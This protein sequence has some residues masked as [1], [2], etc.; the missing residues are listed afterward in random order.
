MPKRRTSQLRS[1]RQLKV[2]RV[3]PS[4]VAAASVGT[5]ETHVPTEPSSLPLA[6]KTDIGTVSPRHR[7]RRVKAKA[8]S[9]AIT[10]PAWE[11]PKESVQHQKALSIVAMRVA[12]LTTEEIA[13]ALNIKPASVNQ[14]MWLA[15][16]NGWLPKRGGGFADPK[17]RMEYQIAHKVVRNID[18]MLDSQDLDT[19]KEVTMETAKGTLFK[20]FG[21]VAAAP[22]STNMVIA[23]RMERPTS[24]IELPPIRE[25]T[26]GGQPKYIE[27]DVVAVDG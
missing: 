12:G 9:H 17:D 1:R 18:E 15:G 10:K 6:A 25:G 19:R 7:R 22:T 13:K 5:T 23:I 4:T 11:L 16:K 3:V 27:A 14:Y 21:E 26:T 2:A 20:K 24:T 8:R